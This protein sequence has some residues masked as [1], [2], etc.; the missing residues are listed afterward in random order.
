M[1]FRSYRQHSAYRWEVDDYMVERGWS[2][3]IVAEADD[4]LLMLE[5]AARGAGVAFVPKSLSRDAV[6]AGR[7]RVLATLG[8]GSASVFALY[9]DS[10]NT[11][12]ARRVVELL[13]EKAELLDK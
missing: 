3:R 6:A 9:N 5:A 12:L 2:P 8:A 13:I 10:E 1:L 11:A 7:V 4:A